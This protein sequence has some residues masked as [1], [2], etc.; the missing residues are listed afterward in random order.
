MANFSMFN[1]PS[2][3]EIRETI[4]ML[5]TC[6]PE[7]LGH[8]IVFDVCGFAAACCI[9]TVSDLCALSA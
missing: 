7:R 6:Y 5:C 4:L 9:S 3:K 8:C 2:Y 1:S